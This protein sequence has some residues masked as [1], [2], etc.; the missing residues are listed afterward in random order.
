[1]AVPVLLASPAEAA[2][3]SGVQRAVSIRALIQNSTFKTQTIRN[4]YI[5]G[6]IWFR[7][8]PNDQNAGI[9]VNPVSMIRADPRPIHPTLYHQLARSDPPRIEGSTLN[10]TVAWLPAL[11]SISRLTTSCSC[12]VSGNALVTSADP[13]ARLPSPRTTT[14][15]D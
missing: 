3:S 12:W 6:L 14:L 7:Y 9:S 5:T 8:H 13:P 11:E 2:S 15:P 4:P 1:M 10:V